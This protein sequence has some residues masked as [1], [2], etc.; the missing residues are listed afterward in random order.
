MED[1]L[2]TGDDRL[3]GNRISIADIDM[4]PSVNCLAIMSMRGNWENGRLPNVERWFAPIEALPNF[5][6]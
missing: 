1:T 4:T 3:A 2:Q 6:K 5:K